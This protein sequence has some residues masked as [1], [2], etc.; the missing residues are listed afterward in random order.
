MNFVATVLATVGKDI[1]IFYNLQKER[2][3]FPICRI[4]V[5]SQIIRGSHVAPSW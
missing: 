5:G 1:E 2:T 3:E 4:Q